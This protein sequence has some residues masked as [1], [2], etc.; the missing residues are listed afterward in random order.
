[1]Q[2]AMQAASAPLI[3]SRPL[4]LLQQC[5]VTRVQCLVAQSA[6]LFATPWTVA[7]QAPLSMSFSR[8]EYWS[9]LPC[10]LPGDLPKPGI[11][12]RSPALPT[13]SLL[14]R[15]YVYIYMPPCYSLVKPLWGLHLPHLR[16]SGR[17]PHSGRSNIARSA[18]SQF[19]ALAAI[20]SACF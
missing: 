1:M 9:G 4:H 19:S 11:E 2:A 5:C 8:Q 3:S 18:S 7:R 6:R 20:I 14:S 12:L 10:L 17:C 13:D 15:E 16:C